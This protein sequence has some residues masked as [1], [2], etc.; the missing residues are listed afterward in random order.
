MSAKAI[1]A[2]KAGGVAVE[3]AA[4]GHPL[5]KH[6]LDDR[7]G[8]WPLRIRVMVHGGRGTE[9]AASGEAVPDKGVTCR[10]TLFTSVGLEGEVDA[11]AG[12]ASSADQSRS[13][14]GGIPSFGLA[15]AHLPYF[16]SR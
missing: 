14:L 12:E 13:V 4:Q 10:A 16:H 5:L 7:K 2:A 8:R 15:H 1:A 6:D 9:A 11:P 3:N